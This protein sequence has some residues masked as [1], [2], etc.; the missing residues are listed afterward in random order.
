M[1]RWRRQTG[2][3]QWPGAGFAAGFALLILLFRRHLM[4]TVMDVV[5]TFRRKAGLLPSHGE[6]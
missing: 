1:T 2:K 3:F 6:P 4:H 5:S